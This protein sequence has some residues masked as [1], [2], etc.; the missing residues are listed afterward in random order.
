[1]A[2]MQRGMTKSPVALARSSYRA[3]KKALDDQASPF[4]KKKFTQPQLF[5]I[6]VLKAFFK[7][8]YRGIVDIL[9]D[10][11]D[12]REILELKSVPHYS[13]LAHAE[14]RLLKKGL[15]TYSKSSYSEQLEDM[16]FFEV[17]TG[18]SSTRRD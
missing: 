14:K 9:R 10:F 16:D 17:K 18:R 5:S 12:L 2:R 15:L 7:T 4:S 11:S 1:V 3:A 8:D 13:T 6:L